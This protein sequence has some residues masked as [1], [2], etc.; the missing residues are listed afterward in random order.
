[1]DTTTMQ[2]RGQAPGRARCAASVCRV[3]ATRLPI[4]QIWRT[5]APAHL[6]FGTTFAF[7]TGAYLATTNPA[8]AAD[9][10]STKRTARHLRTRST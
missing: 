6:G 10:M 5:I 8:G 4:S 3:D 1:M 9:L 2:H 7:A